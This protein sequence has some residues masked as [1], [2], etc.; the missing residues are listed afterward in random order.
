MAEKKA[1]GGARG[2]IAKPVT[3][4]PE[5]AAIVGTAELPRSEIVSKMWEY[6]KKNDLQNPANKREILADDKLKPIFGADK[7]TMF[8]MNKHIAKHVK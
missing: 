7:V 8:E 2:G 1:S 4:S 6:I 5:L 3:P